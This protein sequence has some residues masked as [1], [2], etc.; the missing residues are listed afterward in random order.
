MPLGARLTIARVYQFPHRARFWVRQ[1][2]DHSWCPEMDLNHRRARLQRAALPTELSGRTEDGADQRNRTAI[3]A[4]AAH[5][6]SN[7]PGPLGAQRRSRTA[8]GLTGA[9]TARWARHMP[10]VCATRMAAGVGRAEA[11]ASAIAAVH[12]RTAQ[13]GWRR[14]EESNPHPEG[15]TVF[16]TAGRPSRPGSPRGHPARVRRASSA[17]EWSA[18]S[19][20]NQDGGFRL[21]QHLVCHA[22]DEKHGKSAASMR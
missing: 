22:A 17:L 1:H 9:F 8:T 16:K 10:G 12:P 13:I 21:R 5:G 3:S 2:I 15:A 14:A 6:T 20:T 11:F 19:L 4:R 18:H 7:I